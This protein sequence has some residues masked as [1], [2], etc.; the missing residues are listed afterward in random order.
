MTSVTYY[1]QHAEAERAKARAYYAA[2]RA[3]CA[4]KQRARYHADVELGQQRA[5]ES[6]ARRKARNK[7]VVDAFKSFPCHYCGGTFPS[8]VMDCH[9][10]SGQKTARITQMV[11]KGVPVERLLVELDKCVPACANC[12][13]GEHA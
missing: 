4:A 10:V 8:R 6:Q 7:E 1:E 11:H 13:R 12:H 9:H 2:N 5:R 3:V